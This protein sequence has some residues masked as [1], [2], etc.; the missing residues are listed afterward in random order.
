VAADLT[1]L[2]TV[3]TRWQQS[4]HQYRQWSLGGSSPYTSTD[5]CHSVTAFLSSFLSVVSR[6]QM[7]L[8]QYRQLSLAGSSPYISTDSFHSLAV[9]LTSVKTK[10]LRVN[11]HKLDK[12]KTQYKQNKTEK[13]VKSRR[14]YSEVTVR[15]QRLSP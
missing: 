12:R 15:V 4:L 7:S 2:Q 9:V 14:G 3:V 1:P 8:H 10:Q 6:W 13:G 5:G 11:I